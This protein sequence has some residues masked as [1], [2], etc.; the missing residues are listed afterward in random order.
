M[1]RPSS[2][3]IT[4]QGDSRVIA[5]NDLPDHPTGTYPV[6]QSDDAY[7]YDRNPNNIAAQDFTFALPANPTVAASASYVP[8]GVVGVMLTGGYI[9]NALDAEGRDAPAHEL[10][11]NCQG[12]PQMD[13]A[14]HYHTL[15][16]C[17]ED[18]GTGHSSLVGYALDG[19]GIF[20]YRGEDG[21]DMTTAELDE[22]HGHT[23]VIEWDG[24]TVEMYH[25]HTTHEYPYTVGCFRGTPVSTGNNQR[26]GGQPPTGGQP[27]SGQPQGGGQGN[28]GQQPPQ[29]ALEACASLTVNAACSFSSPNG[30]ISGTC[31]TPTNSSQL[32]CVPAG[33]P[34]S[35]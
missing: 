34:P 35:P 2:F 7:N 18:E 13:G 5:G 29:A 32:A 24:A 12:H 16:D 21:S 25:Y 10:Q 1:T 4:L 11:D 26:G 15:T 27:Q 33:G 3:T 23:H 28:G 14:Y 20:G 31:Q 30:T 9:F 22:C 19:S 8:M 6:S 17:V